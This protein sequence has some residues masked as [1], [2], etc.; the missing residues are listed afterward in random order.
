MNLE[1]IRKSFENELKKGLVKQLVN[2]PGAHY[3]HILLLRELQSSAIFTTNGQDADITT[4]GIHADDGLVDYSPVMMF[5]RKQTGSDRRKGKELQRNLIGMED[6]MTVNEMNQKSPESILYG[7][8]VGENAVSVTSRVMYDT[9][10]SIRDSSVLVEEKFQNAPGDSYAKRT[11]DKRASA[12]PREPDFIMPGTLF[13][14]VVTL[15]D[16][17]FEELIFVLGLTQMNKRYGAATS[18][19]GRVEN[20]ILGVYYGL[21]EGPS[22]LFLSQE[23]A[24]QSALEIARQIKKE[25]LDKEESIKKM[26]EIQRKAVIE[27]EM[28]TVGLNKDNLEKVLYKTVLDVEIVK[29][30]VK[31]A[32][33][34]ETKTLNIESLERSENL[35]KLITADVMKEALEIQRIKA[36]EFYSAVAGETNP[37]TEEKKPKK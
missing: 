29:S 25:K 31:N 10:Y 18:R 15:R 5:K 2:N 3:V 4:V 13:P 35:A 37:A 7:S 26:D 20:H 34:E 33:D 11:D 14:C 30:L 36:E 19:I 12:G 16:A 28:K 17:T 8:A 6:T 22:N 1:E 24:R 32:F 9:A 21:E 23:V 27:E